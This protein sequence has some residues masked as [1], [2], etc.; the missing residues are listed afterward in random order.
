MHAIDAA[1][2]FVKTGTR[3]SHTPG[4]DF[5]DTGVTLITKE[6]IPGIPSID[7]TLALT[8]CWE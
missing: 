8:E 1:V 5:Y 6:P 3:P 2:A 7:P 4:R